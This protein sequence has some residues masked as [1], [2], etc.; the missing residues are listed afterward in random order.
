MRQPAQVDFTRGP[1]LKQII[2]FGIPMLIGNLFQQLYT[3]VDS[4]LLGRLVGAPA[5]AAAGTTTPVIMLMLAIIS[6]LTLGTSLVTAA[7]TGAG[8]EDRVRSLVESTFC[9]DMLA[10]AGMALIAFCFPA[11]I[12]TILRTPQEVLPLAAA[13]LRIIAVGIVFQCVSQYFAD[14]LRGLGD[15]RTPL[16]F[17]LL[18]TCMNIALDIVFTACLR[19]G[20]RGV[21]W[22]TV[23]S[24]SVSAVL[25][26]VY[27]LKHYNCFHLNWNPRLVNRELLWRAMRLGLPTAMQQTVGSVGALFMQSV[28]NGFGQVAMNAYGAAYKVDNFII[29]PVSNMGAALGTFTAQNVGAR[30]FARARQGFWKVSGLCAAL[31]VVLSGVILALAAPLVQIFVTAG[32]TEIVREGARGLRIL[33]VPYVLCAQLALYMSFFKGAGDVRVAFFGSFAQVM[34]RLVLCWSLAPAIGMDAVWFAMPATWVIMGLFSFL[35]DRR[36]NWEERW[37]TSL[38]V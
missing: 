32:E 15:S 18:S 1:V 31:S 6:G 4:I 38:R 24:Q 25:C 21:A 16:Y 27:S 37:R 7:L 29:L 12:L 5:L 28:V 11:R 22:A 35:Y 30:K 17:L 34:I 3:I 20:I 8:E 13:Y 33:T 36:Q 9:I 10:G 2:R 23:I 19:L 26:A 14:A